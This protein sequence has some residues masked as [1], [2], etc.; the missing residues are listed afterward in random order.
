MGKIDLVRNIRRYDTLHRVPRTDC[1]KVC[2]PTN[3]A[4]LVTVCVIN[5]PS[6]SRTW[7]RRASGGRIMSAHGVHKARGAAS[8]GR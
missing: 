2:A 6:P 5:P 3:M 4:D 7:P 1:L 8:R